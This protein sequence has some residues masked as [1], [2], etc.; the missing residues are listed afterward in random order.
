MGALNGVFLKRSVVPGTA[1]AWLARGKVASSATTTNAAQ[2]AS[3]MAQ[4]QQMQADCAALDVAQ[5][6][7]GGKGDVERKAR[8]A[9]LTDFK[10][11]YRAFVGAVQV[12]CD[13]APDPSHAAQIA[14]WAGIPVAQKPSRNKL[15]FYG[16]A[17]GGGV[18]HLY[19][20]LPAKKTAR[21]FHEWQGSTDGAK[22]WS[23]LG[24]TNDASLAVPNLTPA[25]YVSFRHRTTVKNMTS[26]WSQVIVILVH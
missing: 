21:I 23:T 4:A 16:Q 20:K 6:A 7:A 5:A 19:A 10:K 24:Q 15:D 22:T 3:V 2:L 26:D 14:A 25:T 17:V 1:A 12:L 13:N 8:N 18:V 9:K 11:S